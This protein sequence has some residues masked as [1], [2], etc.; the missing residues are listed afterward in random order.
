MP[1]FISYNIM[2][3]P[4]LFQGTFPISVNFLILLLLTEKLR[5]IQNRTRGR[6]VLLDVKNYITELL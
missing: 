1:L 2:Q 5:M 6:S 4:K 3:D